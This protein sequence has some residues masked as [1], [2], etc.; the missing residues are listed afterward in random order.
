MRHALPRLLA[1]LSAIALLV[2]A[3]LAAAETTRVLRTEI[4][5]GA[6]VVRIE[7]LVGK[8]H[9]RSGTSGHIVVVATIHAETEALASRFRLENVGS[10]ESP[11]LRVRYPESESSIRYRRPSDSARDGGFFVDLFTSSDEHESYDGRSFRIR[12]SHGKEL[13]A[14]I[15][16][17]LPR[18]AAATMSNL[19]GSVSATDVT[20][21]I[22]FEVSSADIRLDRV[23]GD[24]QVR[25][26]SG[27]IQAADIEGTWASHFSSGDIVL[28][29]FRGQSASF[30]TSSGDVRM[31]DIAVE[32][33]TIE[34]SSGDFKIE[35]A[36]AGEIDAHTGSGDILIASQGKR[37]GRVRA[38]TGSG[39]VSLRI[40]RDTSFDARTTMGSGDLSVGFQDGTGVTRGGELVA[41]RRGEGTVKIE[42]ETG[43]GNV[44][45]DPR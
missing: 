17:E 25:G 9:V 8:M 43:S 40:P 39:D 18:E 44:S 28:D 37:L 3:P 32:R 45:I 10:T 21:R 15:D 16:I 22:A 31:R 23:K 13:F 5:A 36:D 12:S 6:R 4:P 38:R 34:S 24:V 27:D 2:T 1:L 19:V 11:T 29:R 33:L 14:D 26:S 41:Y 42:I 30:E 20:G 7:N 35:D